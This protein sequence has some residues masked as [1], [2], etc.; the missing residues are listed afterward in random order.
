MCVADRQDGTQN[1]DLVYRISV[2]DTLVWSC[3]AYFVHVNVG[4]CEG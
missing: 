4:G 1:R 2:G 3:T